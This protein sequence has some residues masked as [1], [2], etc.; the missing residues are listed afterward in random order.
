[1]ADGWGPE[2]GENPIPP[3]NGAVTSAFTP[4]VLDVR[5]DDPSI[6]ARN[7]AFVIV[8]VNVYRSDVTDRGPYYRLND[9]PVGGTFYRDQSANVLVTETVDWD[10]AWVNK[11]DAPND[12]RWVFRTQLLPIVKQAFQPPYQKATPADAPSD[13][14]V[15]IDGV[16]V[17]VHAVYGPSGEVTLIDVSTYDPAADKVVAAAIPT[18]SSTVEVSYYVGRN[19]VRSGL[20]GNT[21]YRLTTVV[22]DPTSPSGYRETDLNW[23]KPFSTVAVEEMDYIWREAVRRNAWI[24]QQGGERVKIFVRRTTGVPCP[25]RF[26]PPYREMS[27]Q[28]SSRCLDCFGT[29]FVGGYEGPYDEILAPDDAERKVSQTPWGRRKDH[30]YDVF[31]GPSPVVTQRDFVVKQNNERYTIGPVRRPTNRGNL[32]QQHFT[33]GSFDEGDIRYRVPIDGTAS[34]PWPQTRYGFR[35]VPSMPVDG[36]LRMPPSTMPDAPAYP[37]GPSVQLPMQTEKADVPDENQQR[38]RTPVWENQNEVF[39]FAALPLAWEVLRIL[40]S[41]GWGA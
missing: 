3:Q 18:A 35:Q 27:K 9:L 12:R 25:C 4:G 21:F 38:G 5:W 2:A 7:A 33:L 36:E 13:V 23:C 6:L 17:P 11:A 30:T 26:D 32:L 15:A 10:T 34:F 1:M 22:L 20:E 16:A 28:P 14:S 39:W 29:G 24:L 37:L 8:G 41:M 31:M 40:A 19:H